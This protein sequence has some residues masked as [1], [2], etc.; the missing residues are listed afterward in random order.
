M[1]LFFSVAVLLLSALVT[2][3]HILLR[4]PLLLLGTPAVRVVLNYQYRQ[5]ASYR[6]ISHQFVMS[7]NRVGI[8]HY[9]DVC[10]LIRIVFADTYLTQP[11]NLKLKASLIE[12]HCN[13]NQNS[14]RTFRRNY[15]D[16]SKI[17]RKDKGTRRAK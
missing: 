3:S 17:T 12:I 6:Y 13:P 8:Q 7:L 15:Q 16:D 4:F 11:K 9:L 10:I 5:G 14:S 1:V 2:V